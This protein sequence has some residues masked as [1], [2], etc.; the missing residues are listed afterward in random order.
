METLARRVLAVKTKGF[1]GYIRPTTEIQKTFSASFAGLMFSQ[2]MLQNEDLR[3][4]EFLFLATAYPPM[5]ERAT[6]DNLGV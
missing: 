5:R 1:T 3:R 2:C 4:R 6:E